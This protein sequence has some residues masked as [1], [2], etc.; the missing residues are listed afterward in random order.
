MNLKAPSSKHRKRRVTRPTTN[1]SA[2]LSAFVERRPQAQRRPGEPR[3]HSGLPKESAAS[4]SEVP[5]DQDHRRSESIR[6]QT[7]VASTASSMK[8]TSSSA[9]WTTLVTTKAWRTPSRSAPSTMRDVMQDHELVQ[10]SLVQNNSFSKLSLATQGPE[11]DQSC[12]EDSTINFTGS[13]MTTKSPRTQARRSRSCNSSNKR[14]TRE[15]HAE[16][17][18]GKSQISQV[19][20]GDYSHKKNCSQNV[21]L[22]DISI[23][24]FEGEEKSQSNLSNSQM[25]H[26]NVA[27]PA[28]NRMDSSIFEKSMR[29]INHSFNNISSLLLQRCNNLNQSQSLKETCSCR[30]TSSKVKRDSARSTASRSSAKV[31]QRSTTPRPRSC[32]S[33]SPPTLLQEVTRP[34]P[35]SNS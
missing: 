31:S 26:L 21:S 17:E 24:S 9:S 14:A 28:S 4:L 20:M 1:G 3:Y 18:A 22:V 30:S 32:R 29:N 10:N 5:A 34:W 19:L 13:R 12:H 15:D 33:T 11:R 8:R 25:L 27:Q 16:D 23:T 6:N 35:T 2:G 7:F